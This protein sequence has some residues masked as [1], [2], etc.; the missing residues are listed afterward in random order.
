MKKTLFDKM[1]DYNVNAARQSSCQELE[2]RCCEDLEKTI[3]QGV[4]LLE[5]VT[6]CCRAI[7]SSALNARKT[8]V[9]DYVNAM[10][11]RLEKEKPAGYSIR[12]QTLNSLMSTSLNGRSA[13]NSSVGRGRGAIMLQ[14]TSEMP[15]HSSPSR[16]GW[17]N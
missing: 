1:D 16:P 17:R 14:Y 5:K 3:E 8:T 4:E 9:A 7:E 11:S 10:K 2:K 12:I 13:G 6:E 15:G